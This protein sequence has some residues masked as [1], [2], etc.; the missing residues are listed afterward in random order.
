MLSRALRVAVLCSRRAPGLR[1][2]L[3][4][5]RRRAVDW[6]IVCSVSS[7]DS[8]EEE[9]EVAYQ[10]VPVIHHPV[11]RFYA[12][13][14]PTANLSDLGVRAAYDERTAARDAILAGEFGTRSTLHVVTDR[15]DDGP[16]LIRSR[17]FPVA[18]AVSWARAAGALDLL[19]RAIWVHQ[20]WM[21]R[22]AFGP[23]MEDGL[24]RLAAAE[25]AVMA[26][27]HARR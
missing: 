25:D 18:E 21:L 22:T 6:Q 12:A 13:Y 24:D 16:S 14:D 3:D 11:R 5:E 15:L 20:E 27:M 7:E 19:R 2:L 9:A 23:L 10:Q 26:M 8:F 4:C 17:A 1:H